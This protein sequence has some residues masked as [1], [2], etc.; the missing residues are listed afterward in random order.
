MIGLDF[1]NTLVDYSAT[2]GEEAARLGMSSSSASKTEIRDAL[3]LQPG[4]ELLWQKLQAQVY[5]PGLE[6]AQIMPGADAFLEA[7]LRRGI[8]LAIVSHK[9]RY[10]TQA[11]LGVDLREAARSWLRRNN[12]GV[13]SD[14]IFFEETRELKIQRIESLRC[15][16]FVDDLA[17]VLNDPAFP[18]STARLWL[19]KA[20]EAPEPPIDLAGDWFQIAAHVLGSSR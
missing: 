17:E 5:G 7:C 18:K 11:P 4:G 10:A 20:G 8:E 13:R 16:H 12:I 6:H 3:R 1:D 19:T 9:T 15:T 2:F 14:N